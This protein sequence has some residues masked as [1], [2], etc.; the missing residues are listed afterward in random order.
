[1]PE[2]ALFTHAASGQFTRQIPSRT[3]P[4]S[5]HKIKAALKINEAGPR[6]ERD[7]FASPV[8]DQSPNHVP[9]N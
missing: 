6:S 4:W 5:S 7:H 3:M 9:N 2:T 1:M 8:T